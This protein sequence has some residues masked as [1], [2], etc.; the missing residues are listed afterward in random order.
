MTHSEFYHNSTPS[1]SVSNWCGF[2]YTFCKTYSECPLTQGHTILSNWSRGLLY[3]ID[4]LITFQWSMSVILRYDK[5]SRLQVLNQGESYLSILKLLTPESLG[6]YS[7]WSI[8]HLLMGFS[9]SQS[10]HPWLSRHARFDM[11]AYCTS[12]HLF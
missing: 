9:Y 1:A 11:H 5:I 6:T 3:L 12:Q 2:C 8:S 4:I 7:I 10:H